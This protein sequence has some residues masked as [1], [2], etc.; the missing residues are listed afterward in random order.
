[1]SSQNATDMTTGSPTKHII[2]FAIPLLIGNLFQQFYNIID[3][4]VVGNYVGPNAVAAVGTCGST[5]FLFFSLAAGLATGIGVIVAQYYGMG[6]EI[7]VRKAI[8]N[9]GY[10]LISTSLIVSI[11]GYIFAKQ[12]LL[13]LQTPESILP[14]ATIYLKVSC[15]GIVM[16]S[17]YNGVSCILRALGDSKT[18]LYFLILS[19]IVNIVLDLLFV[20]EYHMGVYGVGLATIISQAVSAIASLI[21]AYIKFSYFKLTLEQLKPDSVIIKKSFQIGVPVAVQNSTIAVS[22]MVLQGVVNSFGETVMAAFS[23]TGRIEQIIHQP[24]GSLGI[25]LTNYSGQ[26]MGAGKIDRVK[27]GY[28]KAVIMM[29]VF[30]LA[31][32]PIVYIFGS[33]IIGLFFDE[34][35][36]NVADVVSIGTKALRI[37]SLAYA[38]LG[39]IY[40]PRAV[41]NGCGDT[42]FAMINGICEVACRIIYSQIFTRIAFFGFWGIWI[43]TALTWSTTAV[44]CVYRYMSGKWMSK[45]IDA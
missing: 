40:I 32:L 31:M 35:V 42:G 11:L 2:V 24:Y 9:A 25:A 22:C 1:M 16:V 13:I 30:S 19:S 17:L 5:N 4:L 18:P 34:T 26:N 37:T 38:G 3:S 8:A 15:L 14:D 10:V 6:N 41:L 12:V 23:I 43:T 27:E 45:R 29:L 28:R 21:Y 33:D 44:V 36:E 7:G 20:S 39:L